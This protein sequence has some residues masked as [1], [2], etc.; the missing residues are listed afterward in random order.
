MK[1]EAANSTE[2]ATCH[3]SKKIRFFYLSFFFWKVLLLRF[4]AKIHHGE[5]TTTAQN[6]VTILLVDREALHVLYSAKQQRVSDKATK[7]EYRWLREEE[8]VLGVLCNNNNVKSLN[9]DNEL[10]RPCHNMSVV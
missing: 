4:V 7:Q 9:N 10:P 2:S 1:S 8:I 3:K 6:K 5:E